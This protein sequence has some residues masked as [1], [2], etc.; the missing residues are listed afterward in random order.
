MFRIQLK[1]LAQ[2]LFLISYLSNH[3]IFFMIT[4]YHSSFFVVII[5]T[6]VMAVTLLPLRYYHEYNHLIASVK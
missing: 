4:S 1:L 5:I 3:D 2:I 6:V